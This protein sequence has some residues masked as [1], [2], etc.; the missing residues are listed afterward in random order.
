MK[1]GQYVT[2]LFLGTLCLVLSVTLVIVAENNRKLQAALEA[3]QQN[4]NSGILGPRG[5]EIGA[6]LLRDMAEAAARNPGLRTLL[7]KHGYQLSLPAAAATNR[8][9][10]AAQPQVEEKQSP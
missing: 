1:A 2:L 3:R 6:S 8:P 5:Q 7:E 9:L 4:I 10:P